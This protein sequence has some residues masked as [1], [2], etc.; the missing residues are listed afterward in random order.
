M[1]RLVWG[2]GLHSVVAVPGQ[3]P[4]RWRGILEL[5]LTAVELDCEGSE[6]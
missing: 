6:C 2:S 3:R 1:T 5:V 4:W